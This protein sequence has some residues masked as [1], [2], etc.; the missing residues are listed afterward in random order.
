MAPIAYYARICL[1]TLAVLASDVLAIRIPISPSDDRLQTRDDHA[2]ALFPAPSPLRQL[3]ALVQPMTNAAR[4]AR[5]PSN[6]SVE[7]AATIPLGLGTAA[8]A[9]YNTPSTRCAGFTAPWEADGK[10]KYAG[11]AALVIGG[12]SS[13]GQFGGCTSAVRLHHEDG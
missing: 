5:V 4:I 11:K 10:G 1:V 3:E 13:V 8:I 9:L 7:Q 12:S 6:I 2:H